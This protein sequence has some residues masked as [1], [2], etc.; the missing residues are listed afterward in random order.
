MIIK[1]GDGDWGIVVGRWD[2]FRKGVPAVKGTLLVPRFHCNLICF[3]FLT[4]GKIRV[5]ST[6]CMTRVT[7]RHVSH[8]KHAT[9]HVTYDTRNIDGSL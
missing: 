8:I 9:F 5:R 2:K 4:P 6:F 7:T 3:C 1:D